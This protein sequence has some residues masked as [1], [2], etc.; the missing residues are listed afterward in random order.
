MDEQALIKA[1]LEGDLNAFN[2]LVMHYQDMTYNVAYRIMGEHAASDDATQEAFISAYKKL[3]QYRGGSFKAWLLRIV[4]NACY[5]EL[6]RRQRYPVTALKP[7]LDDGETLEDPYW[8]ED[9]A[10]TPEERSEQNELHTAIQRCI[11][12]LE[13][14]F[15]IVLV[16]VDVEGLD[17]ETASAAVGT[18]LGTIKSRLARARNR[19]QNC[20][21]KFRE[22]LPDLFR[23]KDEETA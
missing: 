5:D 21:Q 9:D 1:A 13:E 17:Y 6:R 16:L 8:I 12:A 3:N 19:V 23:L 20:L 10:L 15:R 2:R 7:E 18:P 11:N 4:T 22:L 14:K